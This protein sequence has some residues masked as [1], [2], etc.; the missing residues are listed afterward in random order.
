MLSIIRN[1]K[2]EMLYTMS[3]FLDPK[4]CTF[5]A[6]HI[7]HFLLWMLLFSC[8]LLLQYSIGE[9]VEVI[10]IRQEMMKV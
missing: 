2:I 6:S 10:Y 8:V 9:M 7:L 5:G 1:C 3:E 4:A